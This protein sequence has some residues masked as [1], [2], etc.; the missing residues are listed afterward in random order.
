MSPKKVVTDVDAVSGDVDA[1]VARA[2]RPSDGEEAVVPVTAFSKAAS[3][4][5]SLDELEQA[6]ALIR[7]RD[8]TVDFHLD[9]ATGS[10]DVQFL[11]MSRSR[12]V[13]RVQGTFTSGDELR[14]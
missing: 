10:L 14:P 11:S 4:G 9:P 5:M 8:C 12:V 1:E 6:I 13:L 2:L 3:T 7:S